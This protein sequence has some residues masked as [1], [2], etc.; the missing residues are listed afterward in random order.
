MFIKYIKNS[1]E[2]LILLK[3]F[4]VWSV[5]FLLMFLNFRW[6]ILYDF[7]YIQ[8]IYTYTYTYKI[9]KEYE[10]AKE[11]HYR[12]VSVQV[13][14]IKTHVVY[15]KIFLKFSSILLTLE[16]INCQTF[17]ENSRLKRFVL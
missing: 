3:I 4:K 9:I 15:P 10:T 5:I 14:V 13:Y 8:Y 16:N 12:V 6:R 17:V 11:N 7:I 1:R 2:K